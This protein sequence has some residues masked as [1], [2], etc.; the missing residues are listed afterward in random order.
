MMA[1]E[2]LA[3]LVTMWY[4]ARRP[5]SFGMATSVLLAAPA[6]AL[7]AGCRSRSSPP[8]RSSASAAG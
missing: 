4:R 1:G 8:V 3:G 2:L 6:L 7:T 5:V